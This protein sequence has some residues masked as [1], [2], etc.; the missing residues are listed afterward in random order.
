MLYLENPKDKCMHPM[1]YKVMNGVI[2]S[3][4]HINHAIKEWASIRTTKIHRKILAPL[5]SNSE[6]DSTTHYRVD[7]TLVSYVYYNEI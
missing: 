3:S 5:E 7:Y 1:R 4:P 6:V 2:Q